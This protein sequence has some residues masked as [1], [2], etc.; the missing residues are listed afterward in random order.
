MRRSVR[1]DPPYWAS[2]ALAIGLLGLSGVLR[3][4]GNLALPTAR[5]VAVHLVY[6]QELL[7]VPEIVPVYWTLCYEV[8]FYLVFVLLQGLAQR[9]QRG[10]S[11]ATIHAGYVAVFGAVWILSLLT[12]GG[13]LASP[14]GLF[15][16]RWFQ[17]FVGVSAYWAYRGFISGWTLAGVLIGTF[18]VGSMADPVRVPA[19][20]FVATTLYLA[21]RGGQ[22]WTASGGPVLQMLGRVSYSLYLTHMLIGCRIAYILA[23]RYPS[24]EL[25]P[26]V[27]LMLVATVASVAFAQLMYWAVERPAIQLTH[28]I[29]LSPAKPTESIPL[30]FD[31]PAEAKGDM[32]LPP[33]STALEGIETS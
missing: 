21:S 16:D 17:F 18:V 11:P 14:R 27:L 26:A 1:L 30:G 12:G 4:G 33:K 23:G 10:A 31:Q 28:R 20:V 6:M 5:D 32:L 25:G 24:M 15:I 7:G 8:Q 22:L 2:I 3:H 13:F 29:R 9:L 19:A